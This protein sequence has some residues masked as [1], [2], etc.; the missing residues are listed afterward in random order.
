MNCICLVFL[1]YRYE[2]S[3]M[4]IVLT[5]LSLS[6]SENLAFR[7]AETVAGILPISQEDLEFGLYQFLPRLRETLEQMGVR[8]RLGTRMALLSQILG[9]FVRIVSAASCVKR[10]S[11]DST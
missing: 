8:P 5:V 2:L 7:V 11:A 3:Y 6:L 10:R 1:Y 9:V 4:G